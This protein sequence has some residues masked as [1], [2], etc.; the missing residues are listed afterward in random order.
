MITKP[1]LVMMSYRGGDRLRRCLNAIALSENHFSR[2]ILS[3]TASLDSDDMRQCETFRKERLPRAEVICTGNELPT[4][5]HQQFWI[6]HLLDTGASMDD[7]IFWLAYDD[8]LDRTGIESLVDASGSWPLNPGEVYLG[9]WNIRHEQPDQLWT[10]TAATPTVAWTAF[11][12]QAQ[13]RMSVLPWIIEQLRQPTYI[14]MSGLIAPLR[15]HSLLARRFP[16]KNLPMRIEMATLLHP[17]SVHVVEPSQPLTIIYGRSDSDRANYGRS[18][19]REDLDLAWRIVAYGLAHPLRAL[20]V[21]P[22]LMVLAYRRIWRLL[23]RR[24]EPREEWRL[25]N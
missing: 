20:I 14:Q 16:R 9:P 12:I 21:L 8:E 1:I 7:W 19:R 11:S 10:E 22:S 5:Q 4:M 13:K 18:A 23:R 6:R 24:P 3:V 2:I 17:S 15:N 25:L